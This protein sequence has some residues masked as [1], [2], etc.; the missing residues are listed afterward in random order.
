ME[1]PATGPRPGGRTV[2]WPWGG[3]KGRLCGGTTLGGLLPGVTEP[4]TWQAVLEASNAAEARKAW[5][6]RDATTVGAA[7][8][9]RNRSD[10][11]G[12]TGVCVTQPLA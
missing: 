12:E 11:D 3:L 2:R 5:R 4:G 6:L 9:G 8:V 10:R 7:T 1:E